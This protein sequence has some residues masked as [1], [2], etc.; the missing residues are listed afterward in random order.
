[1]PQYLSPIG[2]DQFIDANGDP[3]TGG[4]IETYLAGSSTFAATYTSSSGSTQQTNPIILNS[5]GYPTLGPV[6]LTGGISYKFIVKNA[7]G[8]T[9]WT[10][11]DIAGVN[12]TA[13]S[14]SEW[15]ESGL[16]PT[17][18]GATSFSVPGDQ[19]GILQINR[20]LRTQ[21][22]SGFI[23]ST[24]S[25]SV[26]AAGITTVTVVNDGG[27]LDSGLSTVAYGLLSAEDSSIPAIQ[28]AGI[29]NKAVTFA[30]IQDISTNVLLGRT[31]AASG[32]VEEVT[33]VEL[34]PMLT[35]KVQPITA[36]VASSAL[37]ITLN[38]TTLDFRD[39]TLG[40]GT[41]NTRN[42]TAAIS[43]VVSSGSTLGTTNAVASRLYV[44]AIDNAGTV[45]LAVV[46][47]A[48]GVNLPEAGVVTTTAEGGAG[49]A[50]SINTVYSTTARTNVPYRFV[51]IVD[52][53]Q[54]TAGTWA[55]APSLI[56]GAGGMVTPDIDGTTLL[57]PITLSGTTADFNNI[58]PWVKEIV[59]HFNATSLSTTDSFLIQLGTSGSF[60]TTGYASS[61]AM[62]INASATIGTSRTDGFCVVNNSAAN[63]TTGAV[64]LRLFDSTNLW[65]ASGTLNVEGTGVTIG[66]SGRKG[67][68]G[69]VT[70]LRFTCPAGAFDLGSVNVSYRR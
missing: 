37:T 4:Q 33:P 69:V 54:A 16:V 21:N 19:T 44:Y 26:F 32:S 24:I 20:R 53:T 66:V 9:L 50:D 49:A 47:A 14:Q 12:D 1:M 61:S 68:P 7:A 28:T 18:I 17:Y 34:V 30:K 63:N 39:S 22:T 52:S 60:E 15:V 59:V 25:N 46:N 35:S 40:S 36:S 11:D 23:Y 56:Q 55:T 48:G 70:R 27:V 64:V 29:A 3:L 65:I 45:E 62:S 51:G 10:I 38:P 43:M 67:M 31:T 6:W 2:N 42:L 8:A 13:S 58:P 5:L 41:V 57:T